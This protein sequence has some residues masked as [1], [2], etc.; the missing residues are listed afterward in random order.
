MY[1]PDNK[2][3][4][5]FARTKKGLAHLT[6]PEWVLVKLTGLYVRP[7]P[8]KSRLGGSPPGQV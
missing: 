7:K 2:V 4:V 3:M 8:K 1:D 6:C 5:D